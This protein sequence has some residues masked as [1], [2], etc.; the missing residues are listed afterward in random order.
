MCACVVIGD[1]IEEQTSDS[2]LRGHGTL[3][4]DGA[5]VASRCGIVRRVN[6]LV[7]TE[8]LSGGYIPAVGHVLVG[9][10]VQVRCAGLPNGLLKGCVHARPLPLMRAGC[11]VGLS[12]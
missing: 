2:V 11:H 10:I 9:R 6:Q 3:L 7:L 5:L 8:P 1:E 12:A 4:R